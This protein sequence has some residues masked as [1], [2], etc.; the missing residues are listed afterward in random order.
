MSTDTPL[1]LT[2]NA[3]KQILQ[4]AQQTGENNSAIRFAVEKRE[5]G[6]FRY[7]MGFDDVPASDDIRYQSQ[8]VDIVIANICIELLR[9]TSVD[10]VELD[11][12]EMQFVFLNPLDPNCS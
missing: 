3:A 1:T 2:E 12:G 8:G 4:S 9:G 7:A 5:S 6:K 11:S 10:F